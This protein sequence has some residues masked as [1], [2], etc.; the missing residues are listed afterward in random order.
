MA[1][2]APPGPPDCSPEPLLEALTGRAPGL[3]LPA[4]GAGRGEEADGKDEPVRGSPAA[5]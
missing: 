3:G 5:A 2:A 4:G 1:S